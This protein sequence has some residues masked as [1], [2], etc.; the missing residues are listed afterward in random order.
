MVLSLSN[1]IS[2][3]ILLLAK[4]ETVVLSLSNIISSFLKDGGKKKK[5]C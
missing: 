2:L 1:N 3:Q 4:G 5:L